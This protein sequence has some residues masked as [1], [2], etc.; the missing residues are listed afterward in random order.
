[1]YTVQVYLRTQDATI[2]FYNFSHRLARV[3]A[4]ASRL[5]PSNIEKKR[6]FRD[7]TVH[8]VKIGGT[9]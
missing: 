1:M 6:K 5:K 7:F 4:I 2:A 9:V 8:H 3:H